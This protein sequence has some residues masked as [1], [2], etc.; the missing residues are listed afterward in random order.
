MP[1]HRKLAEGN[2][3]SAGGAELD[4]VYRHFELA[5]P[6]WHRLLAQCG[7]TKANDAKRLIDMDHRAVSNQGRRDPR[8]EG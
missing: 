4:E 8:P 3:L 7:G 1:C 5:E 2:K 6:T